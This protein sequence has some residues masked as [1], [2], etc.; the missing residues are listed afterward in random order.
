V[1]DR[2]LPHDWFP[3]PVPENVRLGDGSWLYSTFAF[4][5][6]ASRRPDA[7]VTGRRCGL[8]HGTFFDLGPDAEVALGDLCVVV[9]AIFSTRG[10]VVLGDRVFVAHEVVFADAADAVPP[11]DAAEAPTL[12]EPSILVGSDV[13]I[14]M[15]AVVLSGARI[16]DGAVLG[17][18]TVVDGEVPAGAIA[19][20]NPWR[21]VGRVA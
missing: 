6:F 2:R 12:G 14:G 20:G 19:A 1:S 5:H 9:G 21:V 15:R 16:G 7:L 8:Y 17:A 3:E 11:G 4:R 18:G 13:W 10:R